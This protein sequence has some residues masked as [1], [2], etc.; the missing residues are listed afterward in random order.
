VKA[1]YL[2]HGGSDLTIVN[3]ARV[4]FAKQSDWDVDCI[5][6]EGAKLLLR[7]KDARLLRYLA[8]HKHELPFAHPHVSFHFKAPIFVARQ[9]AKHQVGFVWSEIS[10]R[11][12]KDEPEFWVPEFWRKAAENVK[13][14]SSNEAVKLANIGK[15]HNCQT[16]I[17]YPKRLWCSDLCQGNYWRENNTFRYAFARWKAA[18]KSENIQFTIVEDDL[19]WPKKCP[20]LGIE[21]DYTGNDRG[22]TRASLDKIVPELGY[23]PGNVQIISFLANK[24]KSSATGEQLRTFAKNALLIHGGVFAETADSYEDFCSQSA[25][26]YQALIAQ[27]V[28]AEQ[29][30]SVLPVSAFT[31]WHWTGSLLGWA[32]V[33]GLRVK[34]D[35]QRETRELVEQID[36]PLSEHFPVAWQ[37]LKEAMSGSDL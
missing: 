14:G 20:Y 4:S 32:R 29:A 13:Q 5:Q 1:T 26:A 6:G 16:A 17:V 35:A 15:C 36:A 28:C 33:W 30:R 37:V 3:A 31:E 22:D 12:V 23:V 27:G 10:R 24:M 18:A 21:M 2:W 19:S 34:P 11:Y 9:L 25:K 8:K 7:E